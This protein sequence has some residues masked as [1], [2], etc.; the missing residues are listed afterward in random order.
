[1]RLNIY[2]LNKVYS[3]VCKNFVIFKVYLIFIGKF[4]VILF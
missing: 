2:V 3:L 4:F 1:M